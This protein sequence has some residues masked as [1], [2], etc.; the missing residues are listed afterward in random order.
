MAIWNYRGSPSRLRTRRQD[1]VLIERIPH[2]EDRLTGRHEE[3]LNAATHGLGFLASLVGAAM[4]IALAVRHGGAWH[5]WGC[6]IYATTLVAAYA[7]STLSH[8][9]RHPPLRQAFRIVDQ[10]VIFLFI[11]GSYTPVA[12]AWLRGGP[13]WAL[14]G[15]VWGIALAGFTAK[16]VFAHNVRLGSV[17][18]SLYLVLGWT[19][20]MATWPLITTLPG[21]LVGWLAAGGFCFTAGTIFFHLDHRVRYFHATWHV[22]V[23]AGSVCHYLGI[24]YHCTA[25]PMPA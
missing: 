25:L 5:V 21:G 3:R 10:A 20:V 13:W 8:L 2:L 14:H 7:A 23:L 22:W 12:L 9:F 1:S 4:V 15:L 17:S 24:L 19:P 18:T 16:S 6:A 11:A